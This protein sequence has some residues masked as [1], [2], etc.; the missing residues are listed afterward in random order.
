[1]LRTLI[2]DDNPLFIDSLTE[3]L[4]H[5][6]GV[7]VVGVARNGAVGLR[8]T[9][10]LKPDLV[11]VD[12]NMPGMSGMEVAAQLQ[13]QQSPTRIIIISW[14]DDAEYRAR[15]AAIGVDRFI[16]KTDLFS[17]L[18]SILKIPASAPITASVRQ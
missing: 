2:I 8:Q 10:V 14:H 1:M 15:A 13:Q 3:L 18:L 16:C 12:Q 9:M 11:F 7:S 5:F 17:E 6:P 4:G